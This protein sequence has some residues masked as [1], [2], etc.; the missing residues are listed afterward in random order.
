MST[1]N[2][3]NS[4]YRKWQISSYGGPLTLETVPKP[5]PGTD[6]LLLRVLAT[7]STYTDCLVL[8]GNYPIRLS[9]PITP[10]YD[11]V[12]IVESIGAGVS[13]FSVGDIV[14]SMPKHG[15]AAE[16]TIVSTKAATKISSPL[17]KQY[18]LDKPEEATSIGLT[19]ITAYQMLHRVMGEKRLNA[20]QS[21]ILVQAAAGGTGAMLC[22]LAKLAGLSEKGRIVGTCSRKNMAKLEELGVV[23]ICYEDKDFFQQAVAAS[24]GGK[25]FDAVFDSVCTNEYY[26]KGIASLKAN[27]IYC[28]IGFTDKKKPGFFPME[29]G[30]VI[31]QSFIRGILHFLFGVAEANMYLV[32]TSRDLNPVQFDDDVKTLVDMAASGA[33]KPVI[34][35]IWPFEKVDEALQSIRDGK[36]TGKQNILVSRP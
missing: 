13:S 29:A 14:V 25:G 31:A 35:K 8:T 2:S 1:D 20:P 33:L 10:G 30:L 3:A 27:G 26:S 5:K 23:P 18:I 19:G 12:A 17:G 34:G 7:D 32:T 36:H 9:F 24:P 15:C 21:A 28:F 11:C 6:E 4:A 16:Y 22:Q